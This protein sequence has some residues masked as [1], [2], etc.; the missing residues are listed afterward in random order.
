LDALPGV[1]PVA[2]AEQPLFGAEVEHLR[3]PRVDRQGADVALDEHA[4]AGAEEAGAAVGAAEQPL[5]QGADVEPMGGE[6]GWRLLAL[7][8]RPGARL[9]F[10]RRLPA[11]NVNGPRDSPVRF[12]RTCPGAGTAA[13][14]CRR[15]PAAAL[16]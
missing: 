12:T 14:R 1:G 9:R 5:A 6:H 3:P 7:P 16:P 8:G 10:A 15:S 13:G 11:R 4:L 2:A